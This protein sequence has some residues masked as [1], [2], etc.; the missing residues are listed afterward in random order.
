LSECF[1]KHSDGTFV[2]DRFR[3]ESVN[4]ELEN[5][6]DSSDDEDIVGDVA[7]KISDENVII[8]SSDE[9]ELYF[10]RLVDDLK[11]GITYI[12]SDS[13]DRFCEKYP[14]INR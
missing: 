3:F 10:D 6:D 7:K 4:E 8:V 9:E 12:V 2:G 1:I 13:I 11:K 14:R 5:V